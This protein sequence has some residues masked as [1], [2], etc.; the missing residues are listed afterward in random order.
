MPAGG[1]SLDAP[2]AGR[3]QMTSRP[4]SDSERPELA[5]LVEEAAAA[6]RQKLARQMDQVIAELT[7]LHRGKPVEQVKPMLLAAFTR[8]GWSISD[9][10]L[11]RYAAAISEGRAVQVEGPEP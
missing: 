2:P 6:E 7:G 3:V 9:P 8:Q 4:G 10:S 5:R 11:S 1:A